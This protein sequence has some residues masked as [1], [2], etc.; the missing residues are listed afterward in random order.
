MIIFTNFFIFFFSISSSI[1]FNFNFF[2]FFF[3]ITVSMTL[4][5]LSPLISFLFLFWF[6]FFKRLL[7]YCFVITTARVIFLPNLKV[8]IL[9]VRCNCINHTELSA[10]LRASFLS[11]KLL[12]SL[13]DM[14]YCL[15]KKEKQR[16][17][18]NATS[19]QSFNK[20]KK[21]RWKERCSAS[22]TKSLVTTR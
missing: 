2:N 8:R 7:V 20:K 6:I 17:H 4:T 9:Q 14:F 15:L 13:S 11:E 10:S 19:L 1:I 22:L 5:F 16:F 21:K 18:P 12:S 3:W